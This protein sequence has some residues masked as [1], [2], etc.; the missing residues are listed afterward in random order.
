MIRFCSLLI[1]VTSL[2]LS[3]FAVPSIL[4][5]QSSLTDAQIA[6]RFYPTKCQ[7]F[8]GRVDN[9]SPINTSGQRHISFSVSSEPGSVMFA[10]FVNVSGGVRTPATIHAY[11]DGTWVLENGRTQL[12]DFPSRA[13]WHFSKDYPTVSFSMI[14]SQIPSDYEV[15]VVWATPAPVLSDSQIKKFAPST[16]SALAQE[17]ADKQREITDM[18]VRN[19]DKLFAVL[20]TREGFLEF[21]PV[22]QIDMKS[23]CSRAPKK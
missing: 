14:P 23:M 11:S 13:S 3:L 16:P 19:P 17:I 15:M 20:R 22:H 1:P 12:P 6:E 18:L 21:S 10:E 4:M 2:S 5:A 9:S 8:R 7:T